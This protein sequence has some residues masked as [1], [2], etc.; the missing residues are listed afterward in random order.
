MPSRKVVPVVITQSKGDEDV[1]SA[2]KIAQRAEKSKIHGWA[3]SFD[4]ELAEP[5]LVDLS[6]GLASEKL[7]DE[8]VA[9]VK[10]SNSDGIVAASTEFLRRARLHNELPDA[11]VKVGKRVWI[12]DLGSLPLGERVSA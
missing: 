10:S 5:I 8:I 2:F 1:V 7:V 11:L 12:A 9:K 3:H 6:G 4:F